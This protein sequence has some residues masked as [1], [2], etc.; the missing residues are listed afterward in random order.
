MPELNWE[1]VRMV[2]GAVH[3]SRG[4]DLLPENMN[5]CG[6][7]VSQCWRMWEISDKTAVSVLGPAPAPP[8]CCG[9]CQDAG[10]AW[11][12]GCAVKMNCKE[13]GHGER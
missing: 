11:T 1:R 5:R 12:M 7:G 13:I 9:P 6:E 4:R 3:S 10:A 8:L 2:L